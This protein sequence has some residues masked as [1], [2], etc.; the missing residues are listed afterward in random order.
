MVIR[1][2]YEF[3]KDFRGENSLQYFEEKNKKMKDC[4]SKIDKKL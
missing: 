1:Q 4:V 2:D 3:S